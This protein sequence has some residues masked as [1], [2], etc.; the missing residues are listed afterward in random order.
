MEGSFMNGTTR[1]N[2][3]KGAGAAAGKI[4]VTG[5][6]NG[7]GILS[8]GT[9]KSNIRIEDVSLS[10]QEYIYRAPVKFAGAVMDRASVLT[11]KCRVRTADGK[12]AHGF[13]SMPFNHIFSYP[14]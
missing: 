5:L 6:S 1:R 7:L 8:A 9:R 13:G 4:G 10:Y 2:F 3:L 14:S 11:V 12:I